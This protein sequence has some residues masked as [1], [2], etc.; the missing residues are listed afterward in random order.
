MLPKSR[1]GHKI[2]D[3]LSCARFKKESLIGFQHAEGAV[4]RRSVMFPLKGRPFLAS[5]SAAI[6]AVVGVM[7]M[8]RLNVKQYGNFRK[9]NRLQPFQIVLDNKEIFLRLMKITDIWIGI[10]NVALNLGRW[11]NQRVYKLFDFALIGDTYEESSLSGL[12]AFNSS[13]TD[14]QQIAISHQ[15]TNYE[16][17]MNLSMWLLNNV[18]TTN[19][20]VGYGFTRNSGVF[21]L[22][23]QPTKAT[24]ISLID[25][26]IFNCSTH[27][28]KCQSTYKQPQQL[29]E[30]TTKALWNR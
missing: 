7:Y 22:T 6:F 25:N 17:L 21:C 8:Y 4:Y 19:V 28:L 12:L 30:K 24:D 23:S 9:E 5:L 13:P 15:V 10:S 27:E 16:F 14:D 18:P 11:D 3:C 20:F 2:L 26:K 29:D 1:R